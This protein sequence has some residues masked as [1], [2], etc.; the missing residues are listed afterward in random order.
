MTVWHAILQK[1]EVGMVDLTNKWALVTGASRGVGWHIATALARQGCNLV[2][3]SRSKD[4]LAG[5]VAQVQDIGV[6][7][8]VVAAELD[9]QQQ[10]DAMLDDA[11]RQAPQIDILF[12]NA[13]IMAPYRNNPWETTAEDYRTSFEVNVISL[14]RICNRLVPLMLQRR[15]GR[16]VNVTSGIADQPELAAYAASKAAVDKLVRDFAPCLAGTGVTMNLLD[17]GW[18]RTDLGGPNAPGDPSS[19]IPGALLPALLDDGASGRLF[20]AQDYAGQ[21]LAEALANAL[22]G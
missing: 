9:D 6:S 5:L 14:A 17:P 11:L 3:H 22:A 4:H 8:V 18:L 7:V 15:W 12:N 16:V 20:R 10:V 1:K 19:V 13:A 2:V 21:S